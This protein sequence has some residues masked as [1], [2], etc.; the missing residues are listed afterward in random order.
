MFSGTFL[1]IAGTVSS[2]DTTQN[3]LTVTDLKTK[4][5][6]LVKL[7]ADSQQRK[8]D[9]QLAQRIAMAFKGGALAGRAGRRVARE[10]ARV[11]VHRA[12]L[13]R[14]AHPQGGPQEVPEGKA[15]SAGLRVAQ[16]ARERVERLIFSAFSIACPPR[17]LPI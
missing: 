11:R 2:V 1:N 14:R 5:P 13:L 16:E 7:T 6:V 10:P 8:L 9:P 3:T 17:R 12:A 4:K 15:A